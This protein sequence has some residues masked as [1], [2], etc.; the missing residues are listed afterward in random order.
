VADLR[1]V[2]ITLP[3]AQFERFAEDLELLRAAGAESNTQAIVNAVAREAVRARATEA[4]VAAG[5]ER[6]AA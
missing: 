2:L 5:D 4:S 1:E 3:P 6:R